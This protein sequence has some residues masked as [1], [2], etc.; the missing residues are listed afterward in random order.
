MTDA[1]SPAPG[2]RFDTRTAIMCVL[3]LQVVLAVLL[4]GRDVL[5]VLPQMMRPS[6]R[7]A[8]DTPVAP[9]DQTRRYAPDDLP[10]AP[11][12]DGTP[13]RPYRTSGDM[14][15]RLLF[16][17]T[18]G[19]LSLTGQIAPGDAIRL[20]EHLQTAGAVTDV[21]LNSPGGSVQDA[22][23]IG[24]QL[25]ALEATTLME[26]TDVCLSACPYILASGVTRRVDDDAQVGVHQH[27]FGAN[28]ALP[29]FVAVESI[30]QGQGEVME[31]LNDMGV[32]PLIMRHALKTPPDEIYI[33]LPEELI[34]YRVVTPAGS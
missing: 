24:R 4:M 33:L 27:F 9:G 20:E 21:R 14:P 6:D 12:R 17:Q 34:T 18:D 1:P 22:L 5:S 8:F 7:P 11:T 2:R 23:S 19:L 16:E 15:V 10:F 28:T 32:D 29:A 3:A 30:Q 25:R 13:G 31:Y 26:A